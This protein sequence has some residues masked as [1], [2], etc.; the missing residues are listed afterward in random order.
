MSC[1][2]KTQH[3][4]T[5]SGLIFHLQFVKPG[6]QNDLDFKQEE[7]P[8]VNSNCF[9]DPIKQLFSGSKKMSP[10]SAALGTKRSN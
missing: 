4:E 10:Y 1:I 8:S 7:Q 9:I 6:G 3:R 2:G 5:L